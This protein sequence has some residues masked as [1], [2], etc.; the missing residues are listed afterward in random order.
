MKV[1]EE[2]GIKLS[3]DPIPDNIILTLLDHYSYVKQGTR[4]VFRT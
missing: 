3:L 1:V 4:S 2:I